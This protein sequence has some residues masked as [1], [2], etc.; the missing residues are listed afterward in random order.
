MTEQPNDD[1]IAN[2]VLKSAEMF[3]L[4]RE[5]E[6]R[7]TSAE[8]EPAESWRSAEEIFSALIGRPVT[9]PNILTALTALDDVTQ[10]QVV[11]PRGVSQPGDGGL[12]QEHA[13]RIRG[14]TE[15]AE[16]VTR[17]LR[18]QLDAING[19]DDRVDTIDELAT[20]SAGRLDAVDE[21]LA[22][23]AARIDTAES[24]REAVRQMTA[25]HET[26]LGQLQQQNAVLVSR[27]QVI[28]ETVA[29]IDK[30]FALNSGGDFAEGLPPA[31]RA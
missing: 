23:E 2:N 16:L 21:V 13:G 12:I 27:L 18:L 17:S 8:T 5:V 15:R 26:E 19:L 1:R 20:R 28:E 4:T 30:P 22:R 25:R 7:A 9:R 3:R 29:R 10:S 6:K 11:K 24:N 31:A 14:L